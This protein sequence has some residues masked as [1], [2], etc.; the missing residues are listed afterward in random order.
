MELSQQLSGLV[1]AAGGV[2]GVALSSLL[3]PVAKRVDDTLVRAVKPFRPAIA[4]GIA[5]ALPFLA[6]LVHVDA[7]DPAAFIAAP[8]TTILAITARELRKR[9]DSPH[10]P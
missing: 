8:V 10:D 7:V 1:G 6:K 3:V 5:L 9:L 2:L 4:G